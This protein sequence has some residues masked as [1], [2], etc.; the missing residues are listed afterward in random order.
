MCGTRPERPKKR[1]SLNPVVSLAK[2][3]P[4]HEVMN[5]QLIAEIRAA[6]KVKVCAPG[7]SGRSKKDQQESLF[8]PHRRKKL[9]DNRPK[10]QP[11]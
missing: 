9:H 8:N 5:S 11:P 7:E 1:D 4:S 10:N 3:C 6:G 2:I